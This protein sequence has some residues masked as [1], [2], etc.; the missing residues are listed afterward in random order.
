MPYP[1]ILA[2]Q[3]IEHSNTALDNNAVDYD[4]KDNDDKYS[5]L[6]ITEAELSQAQPKLKL[7]YFW[8]WINKLSFLKCMS[9]L[10]QMDGW[11]VDSAKLKSNVRWY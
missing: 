11:V 8:G 4:D 10:F 9:K 5:K 7:V 6:E 3:I 1:G 2:R